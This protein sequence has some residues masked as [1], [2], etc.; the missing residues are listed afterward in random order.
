MEYI[1]TINS[2]TYNGEFASILFNP[3]GTE[4]IINFG[5]VELPFTFNGELLLPKIE[6]YGNYTILVQG[7][8]CS[9][10]LNVP[11]PTPTPTPTVT[12]TRTPTPTPTVTPTP[13]PTFDPC[14]V[15]TSTP[16]NTPTQTPTNTPTPTNEFVSL[17]LIIEI[18]IS[19][20]SIISQI[21]VSNSYPVPEN[22]NI[23]FTIYLVLDDCEY[24]N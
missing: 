14:K 1:I 10:I 15:P 19:S 12:P 18:T 17:D 24:T 23:K 5:L 22:V 9:K 2:A 6:I 8:N 21:V 13:T 3:Q 7:S 16:T 20:G 11:R 4:D